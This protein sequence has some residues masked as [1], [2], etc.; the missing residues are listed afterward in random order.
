[1]KVSA[2]L[3]IFVGGIGIGTTEED[4]KKYFDQ[5]GKVCYCESLDIYFHSHK[6]FHLLTQ[7][8]LLH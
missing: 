2:E 1:M 5:Y 6:D 3:K 4:V 8:L 7:F